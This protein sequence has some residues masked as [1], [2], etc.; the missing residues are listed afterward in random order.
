MSKQEVMI[1]CKKCDVSVPINKATYDLSGKDLIC[2]ECYNKLTKGEEPEKYKTLQSA[3]S[4]QVHYKCTYCKHTFSRA[5]DFHFNGLCFNCGKPNV[6]VDGKHV[7]FKDR[8]SLL[9][10]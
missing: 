9:D 7:S 6:E 10:Y 8:K 4:N 5:E 3:N 1:V 2:F